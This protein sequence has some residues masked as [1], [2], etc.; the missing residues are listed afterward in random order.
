[1]PVVPG[2]PRFIGAVAP[3]S[4]AASVSWRAPSSGGS[5][6]TGYR[7]TVSPGGATHDYTAGTTSATI[8]GLTNGTPYTFTIHASNAV[9]VGAESDQTPPVTPSLSALVRRTPANSGLLGVF[10]STLGRNLTYGDLTVHTGSSTLTAGATYHRVLFLT[11][12]K[13]PSGDPITLDQCVVRGVPENLYTIGRTTSTPAH[14]IMVDT[15]I[16]GQG[17]DWDRVT[18]DGS[19]PGT[20]KAPSAL[21]QPGMAFTAI[22]CRFHSGVDLLKP[23]DNPPGSY[24]LI[25]DCLIHRPVFPRGSHSDLLHIAGS[26]A[27]DVTMR[28]TTLNGFRTDTG[29]PQRWASSS[30]VQWGSFPKEADGVTPRAVLRD[31]LIEDCFVDGGT[32]A[33]RL[34]PDGAAVCQN[35]VLRRN[36]MG[37]HHQYGTWATRNAAAD[38]GSMVVEDTVWDITGTTDFGASVLAGQAIP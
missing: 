14:L 18:T 27:H 23:Q 8:T 13:V 35:V 38:G 9:G 6:I 21:M 33:S 28:R 37:L 3:N 24:I 31:I 1:M 15:E 16:D 22:R 26:G 7:L 2:K 20:G 32:Y 29:V 34:T 11:A 30:L 17:Y 5:P 19:Q 36:R 12:L 4:A 10:D 25:E